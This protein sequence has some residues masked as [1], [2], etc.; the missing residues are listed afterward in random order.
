[1]ELTRKKCTTCNCNT[2]HLYILLFCEIHT[3]PHMVVQKVQM[4]VVHHRSYKGSQSSPDCPLSLFFFLFTLVKQKDSLSVLWSP[5][6]LHRYVY[7]SFLV[8]SLCK[9]AFKSEFYLRFVSFWYKSQTPCC[10]FKS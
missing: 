2:I 1:M 9:S 4:N 5:S 7:L 3:T 8:H 10:E 6:V